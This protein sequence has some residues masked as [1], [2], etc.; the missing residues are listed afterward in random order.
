MTLKLIEGAVNATKTY[1]SDNMAAKL[2]VLDVE[3]ADGITLDDIKAWYTAE[4][5]AVPEYPAVFILGERTTIDGEGNGWVKSTHII[6]IA[7][8]ATNADE[9]TLKKKLYRYIRAAMELLIEARSS[10]G[11]YYVISFDDV[12]FSPLFSAAGEF[13][14]DASLSISL[15]ITEIK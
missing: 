6:T 5:K 8:M 11:W 13:L 10:A 3:Y 7:F 15:Q 12:N 9:E 4:K 14:S 2:D 1:L